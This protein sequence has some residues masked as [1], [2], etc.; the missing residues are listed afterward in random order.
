MKIETKRFAATRKMTKGLQNPMHSEI[1]NA[2]LR[3]IRTKEMI[4]L[5]ENS[6]PRLRDN[7]E[8]HIMLKQMCALYCRL[9][10]ELTPLLDQYLDEGNLVK[11]KQLSG[12]VA[13]FYQQWDRLMTKLGFTYSSKPQVTAKERKNYNPKVNEE[14]KENITSLIESIKTVKEEKTIEGEQ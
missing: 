11:Y 2:K 7:P 14:I 6:Y 8:Q 10:Y 4:K 3:E 1:D 9:E 12:T 5:F 13:K